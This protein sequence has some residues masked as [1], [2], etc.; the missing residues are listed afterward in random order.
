M[1][2]RWWL[3]KFINHSS[4]RRFMALGTFPYLIIPGFQHMRRTN[5][6]IQLTFFTWVLIN[7]SNDQRSSRWWTDAQVDNTA[8]SKQGEEKDQNDIITY[9]VN[10]WNLI[11][12]VQ[13]LFQQQR[14]RTSY[15]RSGVFRRKKLAAITT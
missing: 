6:M 7:H 11:S 2:W 14:K 15:V 8:W 9:F 4:W 1:F 10:N 12:L 3:L 5:Q 13:Q